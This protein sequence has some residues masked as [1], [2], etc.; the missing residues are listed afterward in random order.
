MLNV[1]AFSQVIAYAIVALWAFWLG[2]IDFTLPVKWGLATVIFNILYQ[3]LDDIGLLSADNRK[4]ALST[5]G[6]SSF[7]FIGAVLGGVTVLGFSIPFMLT[8][9][10]SV[11]LTN[12]GLDA[13]LLASL[14][15]GL[16]AAIAFLAI[17]RTSQLKGRILG[18][19]GRCK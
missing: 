8:N 4:A 17:E 9:Y 2:H 7:R 14:G 6:L 12:V 16:P 3:P 5:L 1:S 19:M 15:V 18:R 10:S 11:S 13:K